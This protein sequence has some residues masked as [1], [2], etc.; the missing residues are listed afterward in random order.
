MANDHNNDKLPRSWF[1]LSNMLPPVG[2]FLYL[3]HRKRYPNK[4][5]AALTSAAIGVPITVLGGYVFNTYI[6]K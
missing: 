1:V 4:A 2:L 3:K 5:R 6:L